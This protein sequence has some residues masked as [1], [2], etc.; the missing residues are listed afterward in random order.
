MIGQRFGRLVVIGDGRITRTGHVTY[1]CKCDCG[2]T[3]DVW[4]HHLKSGA[5]RSCGC[6][7]SEHMRA[8]R[9]S[10]SSG[11]LATAAKR[12]MNAQTKV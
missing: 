3:S 6:L 5:T 9:A 7:R 12:R 8:V 10:G 1:R 2:V 4:P 11:G